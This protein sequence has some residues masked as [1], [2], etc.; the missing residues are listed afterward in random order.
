M[1]N[2]SDRQEQILRVAAITGDDDP[3]H[4]KGAWGE[5]NE[6][7]EAPKQQADVKAASRE[8]TEDFYNQGR[9]EDIKI[10]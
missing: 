9:R 7:Y 10:K 4:P 6:D 2:L 5:L 1:S 3:Q 8:E